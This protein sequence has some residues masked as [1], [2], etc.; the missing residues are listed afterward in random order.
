MYRSD[1][2]V[3]RARKCINAP[4]IQRQ[5]VVN[6]HTP[7][8]AEPGDVISFEMPKLGE[9]DIIAPGSFYIS[10]KLDVKSD[11]R[12]KRT[13]VPNIGRKIVKKIVIS[14]EGKEI[15][16]V[17]DYDKLFTY[18]DFLLSKKTRRIP[19]GIDTEAGLALRVETEATAGTAEEKAV[20]KTFG[21]T[22]RIPIDSEMLS[23]MSPFSQNNLKDKLWIDI[24]F[25][26]PKAVI[27]ERI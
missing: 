21:K 26:S 9:H 18:F 1:I 22:F 20:E 10:F 4:K 7:S 11:K 3:N 13:I 23:D 16:S 14:F 27:L 17:E 2:D 8:S 15:V 24:R 5:H 6:N 12:K 25:N 19:Q